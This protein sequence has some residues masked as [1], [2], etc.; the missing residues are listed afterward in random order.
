MGFAS[1]GNRS[2]LFLFA[3]SSVLIQMPT[4]F[5]AESEI[6]ILVV[7]SYPFEKG[8]EIVVDGEIKGLVPGEIELPAGSYVVSVT[9]KERS[10]EKSVSIA[11]GESKMIT[12]DIS[13]KP[14]NK[15]IGFFRKI[16]Y[17]I[18]DILSLVGNRTSPVD[19]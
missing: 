4:V 3:V 17:A 7:N 5:S 18:V 1:L 6:G 10:G 19:G 15:K 8:A 14:D 16:I 11:S 2:L 13:H 9:G 12:I